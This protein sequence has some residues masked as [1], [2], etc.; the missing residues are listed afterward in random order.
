MCGSISLT[1]RTKIICSYPICSLSQGTVRFSNAMLAERKLINEW[2]YNRIKF[3]ATVEEG[4]T[5]LARNG[6]ADVVA[7]KNPAKV[8]ITKPGDNFKPGLPL[9]LLIAV[10][11]QDDMPIP[12]HFGHEALLRIEYTYPYKAGESVPIPCPAF[13]LWTWLSTGSGMIP[14]I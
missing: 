6:T 4:L 3:T 11:Q 9:D 2:G 8:A 13:S 7:Y 5:G 14:L 1:I 12:P 10:L